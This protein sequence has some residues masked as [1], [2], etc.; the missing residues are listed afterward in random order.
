MSDAADSFGG[1]PILRP[2]PI[3]HDFEDG[4][5]PMLEVHTQPMARID[6]LCEDEQA[7]GRSRVSRS[8]VS[9]SVHLH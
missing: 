3:L 8:R 9:R 4:L 1:R 2:L 5:L 6:S 7:P